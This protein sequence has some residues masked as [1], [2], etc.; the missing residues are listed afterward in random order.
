MKFCSRSGCFLGALAVLS[1]GMP[2]AVSARTTYDNQ[3]LGSA[4]DVYRIEIRNLSLFKVLETGD[5]D[6]TAELDT[7]RVTLSSYSGSEPPVGVQE[8]QY[9]E[10]QTTLFNRTTNSG[11]GTSPVGIRVDDFV[12]FAGRAVRADARNLW[13]HSRRTRK[14]SGEL[15]P[16]TLSVF[17]SERDCA[18]NRNCSRGSHGAVSI[19]FTL[20]DFPV[21][22]STEC[23]SSNTFK[24]MPVD[25]QLKIIGIEDST[26]FSYAKPGFSR[27][28][29]LTKHKKGGPR[30]MPF[31]ADICIASTKLAP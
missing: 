18:G 22:P 23:N 28:T 2:P 27:F 15:V 11:A 12:T 6:G 20:P 9:T 13:I 24:M 4:P 5:N 17:A 30:L 19:Q 16:I 29:L 21:P 26:V 31:N 10:D 25:D 8:D 1:L 7:V 14:P 3:T